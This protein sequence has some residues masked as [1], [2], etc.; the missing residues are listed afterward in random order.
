M[1]PFETWLYRGIIAVILL[2]VWYFIQ[3]F[4]NNVQD[5]LDDIQDGI[6]KLNNQSGVH[7]ERLKAMNM[8]I[9][10]QGERL[11]DHSQ[12]L[13]MVETNQAKCRNCNNATK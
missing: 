13:R 7:E 10:S 9:E 2:I 3:R 1:T 8:A 11:N 6:N 4:V 12:R 5:K